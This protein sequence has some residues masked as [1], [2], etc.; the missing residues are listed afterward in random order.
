MANEILLKEGTK[1]TWASTDFSPTDSNLS[2][3]Y[4]LTLT[5]LADSA[6]RQG[7]K[8]DF[9]VGRAARYAVMC[10]FEMNV[11]PAAGQAIDVYWAASSSGTAAN[12]NAGG[13]TGTDIAYKAGDE[14]EWVKQLSLIGS[15]IVTADADTIIQ[16][17]IINDQW[18]P[19]TRYGMP[20]VL[21]STGQPFEGEVS[22]EAV[23]MCVSFQPII[24]EIQ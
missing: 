22:G 4:L 2:G 18:T 8:C 1:I 19:P 9:G 23:E 24:D 3:D 16:T 13:T 5:D 6:A 14:A 7:A 15:L 17:A 20:V 12:D 21:N 10:R 11:A